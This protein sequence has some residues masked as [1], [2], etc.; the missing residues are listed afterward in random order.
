M[1]TVGWGESTSHVQA[2]HEDTTAYTNSSLGQT[3]PAMVSAFALLVVCDGGDRPVIVVRIGL[4]SDQRAA[5]YSNHTEVIAIV[6]SRRCSERVSWQAGT[7]ACSTNSKQRTLVK[8]A[9][10]ERR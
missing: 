5:A 7:G 10:M 1:E 2:V 3:D 9:G 4:Q 8:S 6:Y